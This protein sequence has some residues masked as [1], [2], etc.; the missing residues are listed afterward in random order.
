[1]V[2]ALSSLPLRN[3][4]FVVAIGVSP[5]NRLL[6]SEPLLPFWASPIRRST[7][8]KKWNLLALY[9]VNELRTLLIS[10]VYHRMYVCLYA[11]SVLPSSLLI[12]ITVCMHYSVLP[13]LDSTNIAEWVHKVILN[14]AYFPGEMEISRSQVANPRETRYGCERSTSLRAT[15]SNTYVW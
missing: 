10:D 3:R 14:I 11:Y 4:F 1:M 6:D 5:A 9:E 12:Y 15:P 7:D 13:Q 2:L 8:M